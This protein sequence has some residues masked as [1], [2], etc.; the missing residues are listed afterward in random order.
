MDAKA[1]SLVV[2][3]A[4]VASN[5]APPSYMSAVDDATRA[6]ATVDEMVGMLIAV[7]PSI[8]VARVVAAAPNLALAM[9]YDVAAALEEYEDDIGLS[10]H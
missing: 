9:G 5:A 4:L 3:G 8:G 2:L 6:G 7:M 1:H 10:G